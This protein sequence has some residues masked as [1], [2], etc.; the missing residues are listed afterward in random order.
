MVKLKCPTCNQSDLVFRYVHS[1]G[2]SGV[3][4]MPVFFH[5]CKQYRRGVSGACRTG[6]AKDENGAVKLW[7][8]GVR[9]ET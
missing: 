1:A 2:A 5:R 3:Y 8:G 7:N 9:N 4:A 6:L